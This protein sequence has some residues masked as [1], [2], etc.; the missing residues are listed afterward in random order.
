MAAPTAPST[1]DAILSEALRCFAAHGYDGTSLNDIAAE[2]GIRRPTLLHH[3]P[4]KEALYREV[5]TNAFAEWSA[6]IDEVINEP[7]DGWE[8]VDRVITAGFRFFEANPEFVRLFRMEALDDGDRLG[9]DLGVALQPLLARATGFFERQMD[10]GHFRRHD[11]VQ[12]LLTGSGAM[13]SYFSDQRF[14]RALMNR[15]PLAPASLES[16][17]EHF[18]SFFKAALEP[19][20]P[21]PAA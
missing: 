3:F 2:V 15:D 14:L 18:R 12:L 11:P 8:Q 20:S 5:W 17:L 21:G 9:I 4:S 7:R 6:L 10:A 1:R 16:A 13:L 19:S